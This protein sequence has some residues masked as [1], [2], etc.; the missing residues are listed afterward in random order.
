[1]RNNDTIFKT[2][3]VA[4]SLCLFCSAIIS[5]TAVSLKDI[6]EANVRLDQQKKI[7]AAANL[8]E[9]NKTI[10]ELF[11]TIE[12]KI[13]N[14]NTGKYDDSIELATFS[15]REFARD[16]NTSITLSSDQDIATIKRRE[17]YQKVYLHYQNNEISAIILPVRGY[18]LWGTLYGFL[19]LESDLKTIIGLE[20]YQHK[21]TPGLGAEVD[22]PRWKAL[23]AGKKISSETGEILISVI[24]GSVD[25]NS[26]AAQ[27]QVDGLS[28]AT[29]TGNGVTNLLSFW[30]GELGY[31]PYMKELLNKKGV[32]DV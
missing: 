31:G 30:L 7:L 21:E 12:S 28:G 18:G 11:T 2:L 10:E 25:K 14:L 20:F 13:I 1:M 23:W 3:L 4:V 27:H 17:N 24:K 19:A 16:L 6:Q 29:I 9:E 8:L 15:E 26:K 22:N 32:T 5:Y